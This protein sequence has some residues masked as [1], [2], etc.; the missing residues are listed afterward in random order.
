MHPAG[1][2]DRI[3]QTDGGRSGVIDWVRKFEAEGL[4]FDDVLLIPAESRVLR[5]PR[6]QEV[7]GFDIDAVEE[8]LAQSN[9][10]LRWSSEESIRVVEHHLRQVAAFVRDVRVLAASTMPLDQLFVASEAR[11][12]KVL[13]TP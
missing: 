1:L 9:V 7:L 4:S 11:F 8:R 6:Y 13:E 3:D 5:E 2:S 10:S 12:H